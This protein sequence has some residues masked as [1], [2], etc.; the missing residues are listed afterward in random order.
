MEDTVDHAVGFV[1][2]AKPGDRVKEGEP[3]A[4]IFARDAEGIA[5]GQTALSEA[6]R[7]GRKGTLTPLITHRVTSRGVEILAGAAG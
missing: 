4:S 3:I 1:I 6:I 2:T 5:V 7:I